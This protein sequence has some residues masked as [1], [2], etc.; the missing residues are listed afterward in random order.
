MKGENAKAKH[1]QK[2]TEEKKAEPK[3][4]KKAEAPK[5]DDKKDTKAAEP[6]KVESLSAADA[7]DVFQKC[8]MRVGKIVEC[9]DHP[10]SDKLWV[11]QL[12]VGEG[13][14]RKILSGLKMFLSKEQMLD[15]LCVVFANLKER[16][17]GGIPSNGMVL[18]AS[19]AEHT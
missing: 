18:C 11:E 19:N 6:K 13:S 7:L 10:E 4:D 15:G 16:K 9:E 12:E 17:I 5:K 8:D 14:T 2:G 3:K 1:K